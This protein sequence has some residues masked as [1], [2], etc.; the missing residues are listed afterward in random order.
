MIGDCVS[1]PA[2]IYLLNSYLTYKS[3][4]LIELNTKN[5]FDLF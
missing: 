2:E 5:L 4:V 3:Y 1:I